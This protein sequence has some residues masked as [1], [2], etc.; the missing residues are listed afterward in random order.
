[1]ATLPVSLQGVG[2]PQGTPEW[3]RPR[4]HPP[5]PSVCQGNLMTQ[6]VQVGLTDTGVERGSPQVSMALG[7]VTFQQA[8]S[9]AKAGSTSCQRC[10]LKVSQ[11]DEPTLK[12]GCGTQCPGCT[13]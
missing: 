6:R 8:L 2:C 13:Y 1:M 4:S 10:P 9:R 5:Q 3:G 11:Q 12:A 7:T